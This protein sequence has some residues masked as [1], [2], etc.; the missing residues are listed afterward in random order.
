MAHSEGF[1][2]LAADAKTRIKE[3]SVDGL[4][5]LLEFRLKKE[6]KAE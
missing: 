6:K 3:I 4:S 2:K 1:Q 5:A